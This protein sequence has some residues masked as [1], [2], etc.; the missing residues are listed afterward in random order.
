M[1]EL[2]QQ[3]QPH[4]DKIY[5]YRT[6]MVMLSWDNSTIAP[7]EAIEFTSKAIGILSGE[8]YNAFINKEVEELL[9]KSIIFKKGILQQI[10]KH[11]AII[12]KNKNKTNFFL[13]FLLKTIL[14][15][16]FYFFDKICKKRPRNIWYFLDSFYK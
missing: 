3:L 16:V 7:K 1:S 4:L 13:A 15:L 9:E 8:D 6:A 2:F 5:A 12:I 14:F 11:V 10:I